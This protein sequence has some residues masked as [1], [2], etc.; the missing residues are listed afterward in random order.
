MRNQLGL[1]A[2]LLAAS[3]AIEPAEM[4]GEDFDGDGKADG[5]GPK[6]RPVTQAE[7]L[8]Y[9]SKATLWEPRDMAKLNLRQGPLGAV[10]YEAMPQVTMPCRFVEPEEETPGGKSPKFLCERTVDHKIV[11]VKYSR[12]ELPGN[13]D[14]PV[15][16]ETFGEPLGT[17]LFWALGFF[18]DRNYTTKVYCAD[19][20]SGDPWSIYNG[21]ESSRLSL[22]EFRT[23]LV[24]DKLPGKKIEEC[25][26]RSETDPSKCE[27]TRE[28]QGWSWDEL[29]ANSKAPREQV[30]ALRLLAAFVQHAD[31]KA[32]NQR[33]LCTKI[34]ADGSCAQSVAFVQDLG[35]SFGAKSLFSYDKAKLDAWRQQAVW[36]DRA[37]CQANLSVHPAGGLE[38]PIVTE[39]ARRFLADL[40]IQLTDLQI[41]DLF[42]GSR[43]D[44]RDPTVSDPAQR[45]LIIAEWVA[46]FK[47]KR[48]QLVD[49][50]CP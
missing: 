1:L 18:A 8:Q 11:K 28:D 45:D 20:P 40:M 25:V 13:R 37:K 42:R 41:E 32:A 31:N 36:R 38:H 23:A 50:V 35:V 33:M 5:A 24:E 26:K 7:R 12:D 17:R 6:L 44:H 43:V 39:A 27:E 46:V 15:N 14:L 49:H 48:R 3:C 47:D 19:C 21:G 4:S 10:G 16:G 9:L 22:R 34:A 2:A 30:D 29:T